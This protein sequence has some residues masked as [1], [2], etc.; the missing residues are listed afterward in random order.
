MAIPLKTSDSVEI[1]ILVDNYTDS[2]LTGPR[3]GVRRPVLKHGWFL[4]AEH[5]LSLLIRVTSGGKTRSILM[6][7]GVSDYALMYNAREVGADIDA[8]EEIVLS[9]G[10]FD[11]VGSLIPLLRTSSCR[12]PVHLHPG[13][14]V[15]RRK[16]NQDGVYTLLP[17][18]N[19]EEVAH[20]GAVLNLSEEPSLIADRT[21]LL[22]GEIDRVT[23]FEKGSPILE[24]EL[25]GS[26]ALD[27]FHDDQSLVIHLKDKG[28]IVISGCAHA[29][30]VN[31]VQYTRKITGVERIHAI[32]GGFHL[33]G[34]DLES[35][36]KPTIAAIREMNPGMVVPLHC[37]GWEAQVGFRNA[38]P[39]QFV[40]NSVG[41]RYTFGEEVTG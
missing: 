10:H 34:S 27:P 35:V 29:G 38:M 2:L 28:L 26:W 7:T 4:A 22:T 39:D 21:V 17:T 37:T 20:A 18:L 30:I 23:P 31:S 9:H 32:I 14:F 3:P 40:L 11:H 33:S 5:G 25:N 6:D 41:T 36:I 1:T 16:R 19:R 15:R 24:A 8:V 12:L 13:A